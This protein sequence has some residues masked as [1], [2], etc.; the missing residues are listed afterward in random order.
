[1]NALDDRWMGTPQHSDASD[2]SRWLVHLTTSE[3]ALFSILSQGVI[4]ASRP[5][6]HSKY[7]SGFGKGQDVVALTEVPLTDLHRMTGRR[8]WGVV[9]DKER[10]RAKFAAQPV[11]YV[12]DPSPQAEAMTLAMAQAAADPTAPIW[13]LAPFI[14]EVRSIQSG[15]PNDWRWER[16]WRIIGDLHF[17]MSDVHMVVTNEGGRPEFLPEVSVGVPWYSHEDFTTQWVDGISDSW[18]SAMDAMLERFG[19]NFISP[20]DAALPWDGEDGAYV[21]LVDFLEPWEAMDEVFGDLNPDLHE[22]IEAM[23]S[24]RSPYWCRSYD[25]D[26]IAD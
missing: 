25:I 20:E 22:Q 3:E 5:Y 9:F 8:G 17:S 12:A 4:R 11:W 10:L 21:E 19:E 16:E 23:L 18:N 6:T 14:E 13:D 1:M 2:L 24:A 15:R 26:H 7:P